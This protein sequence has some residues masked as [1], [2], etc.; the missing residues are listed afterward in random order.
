MIGEDGLY[1]QAISMEQAAQSNT[2]ADDDTQ[3][4]LF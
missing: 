4:L 3:I 2:E 1:A